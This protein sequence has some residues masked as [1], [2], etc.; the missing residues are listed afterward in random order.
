MQDLKIVANTTR[1]TGRTRDRPEKW[2]VPD[3]RTNGTQIVR[4]YRRVSSNRGLN[5]RGLLRWLLEESEST[6]SQ[7]T[8]VGIGV[9]LDLNR[10]GTT[11][12]LKKETDEQVITRVSLGHYQYK[13]KLSWK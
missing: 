4:D 2:R 1:P 13:P 12:S 11:T 6:Q 3:S 8:I 7:G 5:L 9:T 10:Q